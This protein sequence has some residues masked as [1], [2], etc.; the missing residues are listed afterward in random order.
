[1]QAQNQIQRIS[2]NLVTLGVKPGSSL[3][4]H[5][6][7]SS[8][9]YIDGGPET[10]IQGLLHAL[11]PDGTLLVPAL[12]Y[13]IVTWKNPVFDVRKTP[14]NIGVIPEYF[15]RRPGTKRSIHPTHSVCGIG[16]YAE[17][18]LNSH[19]QD[20]TPVGPH[21]PFRILC[22]K[23]GFI[24]MLGCGLKP[25]TS[26][27]GIEELT[28]PPYLFSEPIV[29]MITGYNGQRVT[30]MYTPHN[31][32]GWEQKYDRISRYLSPPDIRQGKVLSAQSYLIDAARLWDVVHEV[33]KVNP[34]AFVASLK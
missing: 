24:L 10:V 12:S 27:H 14:S 9:G 2:D 1:M 13:E 18:F 3:L 11:G 23:K 16:R 17:D 25:N 19:S 33:M 31:F 7:L 26:M 20:V 21:S 30:K 28:E 29:Y 15:R 22:E 5:S 32:N 6:S 4:V 34:L 8:L